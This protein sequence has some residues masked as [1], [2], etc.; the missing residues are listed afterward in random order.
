V[1]G[2]ARG[3]N[4]DGESMNWTV[5][6]PVNVQGIEAD[7]LLTFQSANSISVVTAD[8]QVFP[9]T[10]PN[11]RSPDGLFHPFG[12]VRVEFTRKGDILEADRFTEIP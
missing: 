6:L 3:A 8:G 11:D 7:I 9:L 2:L 4:W 5:A 1:E 10:A 12:Q